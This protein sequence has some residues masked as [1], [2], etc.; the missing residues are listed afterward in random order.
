MRIAVAVNGLDSKEQKLSE[1]PFEPLDERRH[2]FEQCIFPAGSLVASIVRTLD[3]DRDAFAVYAM[4]QQQMPYCM[5]IVLAFDAKNGRFIMWHQSAELDLL[6]DGNS[7]L[8]ARE[9]YGSLQ[10]RVHLL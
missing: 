7:Y 9:A 5:F 2:S 4:S 10:R 8:L 1:D 6:F 3:F